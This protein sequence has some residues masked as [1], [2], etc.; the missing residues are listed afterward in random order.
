MN[1]IMGCLITPRAGVPVKRDRFEILFYD[2][3]N[4]DYRVR[5]NLEVET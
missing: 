3:L 1:K 4:R 5:A 2:R